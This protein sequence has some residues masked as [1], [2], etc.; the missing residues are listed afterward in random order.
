MDL[1]GRNLVSTLDLT[2]EEVRALIDSAIA[3]KRGE[4][5]AALENRVA[6]LQ[7]GRVAR[8]VEA[9]AVS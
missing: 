2:P 6:A 9:Q 4:K 3:L 5:Q 1:R 7:A 8:A